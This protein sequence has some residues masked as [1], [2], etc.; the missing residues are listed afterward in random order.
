MEA[1]LLSGSQWQSKVNN[2]KIIVD[3]NKGSMSVELIA[4]ELIDLL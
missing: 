1:F 2:M 3:D 4:R